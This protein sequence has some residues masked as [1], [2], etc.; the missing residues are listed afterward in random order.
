VCVLKINN[1][2]I[3]KGNQV[4]VSSMFGLPI[5]L[6]LLRKEREIKLL[7]LDLDGIILP[8]LFCNW[9]VFFQC[10]VN[11]KIQLYVYIFVCIVCRFFLTLNKNTGNNLRNK[12]RK[13]TESSYKSATSILNL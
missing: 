8:F 4:A 12:V 13:K 5:F 1:F 2:F 3:F 7:G 6:K 10:L 11:G 9:L